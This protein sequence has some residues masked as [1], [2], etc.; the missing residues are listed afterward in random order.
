MGASAHIHASSFADIA[1]I[2]EGDWGWRARLDLPA[3]KGGGHQLLD[4]RVDRKRHYWVSTVFFGLGAG[5]EIHTQTSKT[6]SGIVVE[7]DFFFPEPP[8]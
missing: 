1:L 5:V 4:L 6:D 7:V 2:D 3:D 8:V